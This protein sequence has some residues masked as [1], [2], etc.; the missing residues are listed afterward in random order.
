MLILKK[1][2]CIIGRDLNITTEVKK[3]FFFKKENK[4]KPTKCYYTMQQ[5]INTAESTFIHMPQRGL[6]TAAVSGEALFGLE[7]A[8]RTQ[9]DWDKHRVRPYLPHCG[10]CLVNQRRRSPSQN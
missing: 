2:L 6:L 3:F 4:A 9:G 8:A 1:W 10:C 5:C 7:V